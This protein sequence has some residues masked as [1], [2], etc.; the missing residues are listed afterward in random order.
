MSDVRPLAVMLKVQLT[1]HHIQG[2]RRAFCQFVPSQACSFK[3][4]RDVSCMAIA[5]LLV[6]AT[7]YRGDIF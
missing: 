2:L 5:A 7:L 4:S 6:G 1:V 3:R